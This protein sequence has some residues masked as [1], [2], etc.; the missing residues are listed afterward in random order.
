L[1]ALVTGGAGFIGHHLVRGL[2]ERGDEVRVLDD[3]SSGD[4]ARLDS[5]GLRPGILE[6]SILDRSALERAIAGCD[7]VFH[8]AAVASVARSMAE[9]R[10]VND[11]NVDG[12]IEVVEAAARHGLARVVFAGSSAVYGTPERQPCRED[13]R[14]DPES[15]YG[16]SKL[17]GEHYLHSVGRARGVATVALRYFNVFGPGQDPESEYAAVIP[18]FMTAVLRGDRPT[19]NGSGDISRDFIHVDNV[20][21]ANLLAAR[22]DSPSGL[23]CN[24]ASGSETTL[25]ELLRAINGQAGA[26]VE[27]VFGP[28]RAGDIRHSRA[29]ISLAERRLGYR[30]QVPFEEGIAQTVTWYRAVGSPPA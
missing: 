13:Q 7:V 14:A 27:P 16:A 6:G 8:L 20:V 22:T 9:P 2:L 3:F 28:P 4:R 24:I 15:P 1:R 19:I 29:D 17:A 23:T 5:F 26:P 11:V 18:R 21:A 25:L 10:L 12:T 30:V